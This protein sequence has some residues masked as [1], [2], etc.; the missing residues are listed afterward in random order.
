MKRTV[1]LLFLITAALT[2]TA[3]G[4]GGKTL[5]TGQ[6][7]KDLNEIAAATGVKGSAECPS[8]V[9]DIKKGTTYEC[10]ITYADNENNKQKVQMK[11]GDNDESEFADEE[12]VSDEAA[13]RGIVA[14]SDKDPATVCEHLS[15]DVLAQLGG[16]DCPTKAAEGDD[17]KPTVIKS[18]ALEG[19]SATMTTDESSST[20][21]R[22]EDGSWIVTAI[23]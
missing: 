23:E 17:G 6:V 3:C 7:E 12:A 5:D 2:V 19:D 20:F 4:G 8:E 11:V 9:E 1:P 15:E 18:I 21:E 22:S 16:D 13:I 14:Q 10:T